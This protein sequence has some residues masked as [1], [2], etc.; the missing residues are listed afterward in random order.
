MFNKRNILI[1]CW[2][3]GLWAGGVM[4]TEPESI[5]MHEEELMA[6][7]GP[8]DS[9]SEHDVIDKQPSLSSEKKDIDDSIIQNQTSEPC[10]MGNVESAKE[11][12]AIKEIAEI[13]EKHNY[14]ATEDIFFT[15]NEQIRVSLSNRDINKIVVRGDKIRSINGPT[16]FYQAKNDLVGAVYL[17]I[18]GKERFTL[19]LTT[20]NGRSC[21]LLVTPKKVPGRTL[22]LRG[23]GLLA[24]HLED[25]G[26]QKDL[27]NFITGMINDEP[28][29][30]YHKPAKS[31]KKVDFYDVANI[32]H[33]A[34]Y[35]HGSLV[36]IVAAVENKSRKSITLK[37][38]YFYQTGVKAVALSKQ[39]LAPRELALLYQVITTN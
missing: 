3:L 12:K 37:P 25:D 34:S 5:T 15:D 17:T 7:H 10:V 38:N 18:Y 16:N 2:C 28:K 11:S 35:S 9:Q 30:I 22:V 33:V 1:S 4:A 20:L 31:S 26:Y 23:P 21:S 19:F 32:K 39:T 8:M 29:Y 36:G 6:A 14:P 13:T 27:V 24:Q